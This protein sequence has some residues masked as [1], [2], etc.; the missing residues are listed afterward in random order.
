MIC[1]LLGLYRLTLL[2]NGAGDLT[3]QDISPKLFGQS[4]GD[5]RKQLSELM[6]QCTK[7]M[8]ALHNKARTFNNLGT[9]ESKKDALHAIKEYRELEANKKILTAISKDKWHPLPE[10]MHKAIVFTFENVQNEEQKVEEISLQTKLN[11]PRDNRDAGIFFVFTLYYKDDQIAEYVKRVRGPEVEV[12]F[13]LEPEQSQ[14]PQYLKIK[15]QSKRKKMLCCTSDVDENTYSLSQLKKHP[16]LTKTFRIENKKYELKMSFSLPDS[17]TTTEG[18]REELKVLNIVDEREPFVPVSNEALAETTEN[19][20]KKASIRKS[21]E[22]L[23]PEPDK[24]AE[25]AVPEGILPDELQDPDVQ[26]NLV[27]LLY[28]TEKHKKLQGA[29][30]ASLKSESGVI[31]P[32]LRAKFLL[33]TQ[34]KSGIESAIENEQVTFEQYMGYLQKAQKHDEALLGYFETIQDSV[35]AEIVRFRLE[36]VQ[37]ELNQE[38]EMGEGEDE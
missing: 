8:A 5:R 34:Q 27:S 20:V 16:V 7:S 6:N 10:I 4:E 32:K 38:V 19:P 13:N 12:E 33:F 23:A 9:S 21:K 15:L 36:C 30:Q 2:S 25:I 37:K 35:K 11:I 1:S 22:I 17:A 18:S 28:C 31:N 14:K 24:S 29:V 3:P 26:R